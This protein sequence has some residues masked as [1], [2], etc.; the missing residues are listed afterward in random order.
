MSSAK[1]IDYAK[2]SGR[3]AGIMNIQANGTILGHFGRS[4]GPRPQNKTMT[5]G[6]EG[7]KGYFPK[8][9]G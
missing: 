2:S 3:I 4:G 6:K 9:R 1:P 8:G 7:N 5:T